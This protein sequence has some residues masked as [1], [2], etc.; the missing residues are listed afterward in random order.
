MPLGRI[1][2][3]L[4]VFSAIV[5]AS[6][7]VNHIVLKFDGSSQVANVDSMSMDEVFTTDPVTG[8]NY[9]IPLDQVYMIFNDFNR[10]FY[11]SPSFQDRIAYLEDWGGSLETLDG[12]VYHYSSIR[13]NRAMKEPE[14]YIVLKSDSARGISLF[15][16]YKLKADESATEISVIR[17]AKTSVGLFLL[18]TTFEI[19]G[20]YFKNKDTRLI[21]GRTFAHLGKGFAIEVQEFSPGHKALGMKKTGV[22]Y[23]SLVFGIPLTTMGWMVYDKIVDRRASYFIPHPDKKYPRNMYFF[24]YRRIF[25]TWKAEKKALIRSK[26]PP[27]PKIPF[28]SRD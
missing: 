27:M 6:T 8:K 15:D 14:M 17:G 26:L 24:N 7:D 13:F 23:H 22:T 3:F 18:G 9:I 5:S 28:L 20:Y 10:L 2:I 12:T 21:S 4:L 25:K 16:I 1:I 11:I 19:L